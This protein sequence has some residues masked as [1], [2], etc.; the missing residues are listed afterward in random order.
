MRLASS[1]AVARD[2]SR[3]D[4]LY[5]QRIVP[6]QLDGSKNTFFGTLLSEF[7]WVPR[8]QR[9][10]QRRSHATDSKLSFYVPHTSEL[11]SRSTARRRNTRGNQSSDPQFQRAEFDKLGTLLGVKSLEDWYKVSY[12][13]VRG[14]LGT[15]ILKRHADS[16][17]KALKSIYPAHIWV[18]WRFQS[19]P[20]HFW[21]SAV[22]RR[23]FFEHVGA[24]VLGI[25]DFSSPAQMEK[26]YNISV[27][28]FAA[29]A[30]RSGLAV[31][32]A[33]SPSKALKEVFPEHKWDLSK[34]SH[35]PKALAEGKEDQ[36]GLLAAVAKKL[37]IAHDDVS[38]WYSI[39][40]QQFQDAGGG[41][42]LTRNGRSVRKTVMNL[43]SDHTWEPWKFSKALSRSLATKD[44]SI[45][46]S[47][48]E[49]VGESLGVTALDEWYRVSSHQLKSLKAFVLLEKRL[50]EML[51]LACAA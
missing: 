13:Q 36:K 44:A 38:A 4:R 32:G 25:T 19:A 7:S 16:L 39:T 24:A 26:W 37:G 43:L 6:C 9:E 20:R 34:F 11:A 1:R 2:S 23:R 18:E 40:V 45:V 17:I 5:R 49:N 30:G 15:G 35:V 42:L 48:L 10:L 14:H 31:V 8:A 41:R 22:N 29:V 27:E 47:Y 50:P 21:K 33:G 28:S 12:K 46:R 51:T 3:K